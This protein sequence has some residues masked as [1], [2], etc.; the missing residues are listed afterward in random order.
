MLQIVYVPRDFKF[1]RV[2]WILKH[3]LKN[4]AICLPQ[5]CF[6]SPS[7]YPEKVQHFLCVTR[8]R[9]VSGAGSSP[10]RI[11]PS[12]SCQRALPVATEAQWCFS[13]ICR[14]EA[15]GLSH[16]YGV[17]GWYHVCRD[18]CDRQWRALPSCSVVSSDTLGE[19]RGC[20]AWFW[21]A[22]EVFIFLF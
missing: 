2:I 13:P 16:P 11:P 5:I 14:R 4:I 21:V 17:S 18:R 10:A 8:N 6:L 1:W 19:R 3:L 12:F 7:F 22:T 15:H 20:C 9:G